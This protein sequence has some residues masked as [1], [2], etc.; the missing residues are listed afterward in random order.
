MLVYVLAVIVAVGVVVIAAFL[1]R[2][3]GKDVDDGAPDGATASH[4]GAMLSALF[5]LV[6]AIAIVVP[7]TSADAARQNTYTEGQAIVAAYWAAGELPAPANNELRTGI[8]D[9]VRF[10]IDEEW[11]L[12]AGGELSPEGWRRLDAM[13]TRVMNLPASSGATQEAKDAVVEKIFDVSN[14]RQQRAADA[15]AMLPPGVLVMTVLTGLAVVLFPFLAGARPKGMTIVPLLL[16]TALLGAG[17][18]LVFDITRVFTGALAVDPD[19]FRAVLQ[20]LER[21]SGGG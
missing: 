21:V 11:P 2:R 14:A 18:Y 4:A 15:D 17:V 20:E 16:M 13:R 9:Y 8:R 10:V 6:F 19:A 3:I 7:W 5:L 12:M 1:F